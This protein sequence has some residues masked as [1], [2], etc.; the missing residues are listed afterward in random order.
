MLENSEL[1]AQ[2]VERF[3]KNLP[4]INKGIQGRNVVFQGDL[5]FFVHL[6]V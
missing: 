2:I 1:V 5:C 3:K 4:L 6:K